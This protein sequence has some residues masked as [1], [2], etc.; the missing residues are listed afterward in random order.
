MKPT[1]DKFF[2][3]SNVA[4]YLIDDVESE[5][6]KISIS[7]IDTTGFIS[8]QVVFECLNV[9][10]KKRKLDKKEAIAFVRFL[11][12]ASYVQ[13][14]DE[15]ILETALQIFERYSLSSYDSK[16]VASALA[17]GCST[18]YSEDMQNGLVIENRLNIVNP[19][20]TS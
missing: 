5:K 17:A 3:D 18:L 6:K 8:P 2:I 13:N 7:L 20:L 19:F 16:I 12:K 9:C 14:E 1:K 4:L 15:A 11:I 10:L